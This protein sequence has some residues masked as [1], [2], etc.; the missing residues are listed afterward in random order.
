MSDKEMLLQDDA[1]ASIDEIQESARHAEERLEVAWKYRYNCL[2]CL[3]DLAS[4]RS[5]KRFLWALAGIGFTL[6][7]CIATLYMLRN[8]FS[9]AGHILCILFIG[10]V[11]TYSLAVGPFLLYGISLVICVLIE[12]AFSGLFP[13]EVEGLLTWRQ[14]FKRA[15]RLVITSVLFFGLLFLLVFR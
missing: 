8:G 13:K 9:D 11:V 14:S 10:L 12:F 3:G 2:A 1:D 6:S 15:A 5:L 4:G 7:L